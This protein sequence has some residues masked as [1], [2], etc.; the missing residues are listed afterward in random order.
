MSTIHGCA[1]SHAIRQQAQEDSLRRVI[2]LVVVALSA[3]IG[4]LIASRAATAADD[5]PNIITTRNA[6]GQLRTFNA[7]GAL[8]LQNPF[9]RELGTNGRTCFT[10]HQPQNAWTIT[11]ENVQA[12]FAESHGTE[13]PYAAPGRVMVEDGIP[14]FRRYPHATAGAVLL[15]VHFVQRP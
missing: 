4:P 9:F 12:R 10:C 13:V 7:N 6:S 3:L 14:D 15:K 2:A 1:A 5:D 8:D 11:P